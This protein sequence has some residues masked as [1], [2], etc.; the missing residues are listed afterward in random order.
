MRTLIF[1]LCAC[2]GSPPPAAPSNVPE[3]AAVDPVK[4]VEPPVTRELRAMEVQ[5]KTFY[6]ERMDFPPTAA[7][8]PGLIDA[9]C[10]SPNSEFPRRPQTEWFADPGWGAIGFW[11][12][13][14]SRVSYAWTR[15]S[16]K[17][18][19]ATATADFDC[20]GVHRVARLEIAVNADNNLTATY[21]DPTED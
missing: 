16:A 9:V 12:D 14:P 6:I 19:Y 18:G 13:G 3:P 21:L 17:G 8:M 15:T 4:P 7:P 10:T 5:I 1:L 2:G 20:D 11:V